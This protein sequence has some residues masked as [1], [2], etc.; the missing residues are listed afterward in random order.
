MVHGEDFGSISVPSA[1]QPHRRCL[2]VGDRL[3]VAHEEVQPLVE[4]EPGIEERLLVAQRESGREGGGVGLC[5]QLE[6]GAGDGL[7]GG[8]S[9]GGGEVGDRRIAPPGGDPQARVVPRQQAM[10]GHGFHGS[11]GL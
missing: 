5:S 1:S 8:S 4:L 6:E 10:P 2:A 9:P 3:Q 7:R 11:G